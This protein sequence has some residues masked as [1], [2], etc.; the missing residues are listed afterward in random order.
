MSTTSSVSLTISDNSEVALKSWV[1]KDLYEF[2]DEFEERDDPSDHLR[3]KGA[4][5]VLVEGETPCES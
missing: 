2:E 3:W 4:E 5:L 1:E